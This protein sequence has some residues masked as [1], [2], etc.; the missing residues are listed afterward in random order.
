MRMHCNAGFPADLCVEEILIIV[1]EASDATYANVDFAIKTFCTMGYEP[2][3]CA[4]LDDA[5]ILS[6]ASSEVQQEHGKILQLRV[7]RQGLSANSKI[8]R[9]APNQIDLTRMG[10]GR[11]IGGPDAQSLIVAPAA[12]LNTNGTAGDIL[13]LL[14]QSKVTTDEQFQANAV[15]SVTRESHLERLRG[16]WRQRRRR[17]RASRG[18][19][20]PGRMG[21]G[22]KG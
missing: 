16:R 6:L 21:G 3:T 2:F 17:A 11:L 20:H 5:N 12:S 1:K 14:H 7:E 10:S 19:C 8:T 22:G 15:R 13:Q 9:I 18:R 4:V